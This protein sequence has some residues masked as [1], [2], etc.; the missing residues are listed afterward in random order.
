MPV[1]GQL[2]QVP[3]TN[4]INWQPM[5]ETDNRSTGL[6]G[7][8]RMAKLHNFVGGAGGQ[9]YDHRFNILLVCPLC[10]LAISLCRPRNAVLVPYLCQPILNTKCW[11]L[12]DFYY[13]FAVTEFFLLVFLGLLNV[14]IIRR[15]SRKWTLPQW[16]KSNQKKACGS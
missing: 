11:F 12:H 15:N 7:R 4:N 1:T 10:K 5:P 8:S 14:N 13:I 9:T 2:M 3:D 6:R 16:R